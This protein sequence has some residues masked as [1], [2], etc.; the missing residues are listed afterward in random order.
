MLPKQK[1]KKADKIDFLKQGK[2]H[3]YGLENINR[4]AEKYGGNI[5]IEHS[6]KRFVVSVIMYI[7]N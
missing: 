4:I 5:K 6:D 7:I 2:E 3:G 1:I